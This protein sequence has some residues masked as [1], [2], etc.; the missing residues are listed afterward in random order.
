ML[1][2]LWAL[3]E[4]RGFN[5]DNMANYYLDCETQGLNPD[6]DEIVTIQYQK[7]DFNTGE[8]AGP[9]VILKAWESSEKDILEKF[10]EVFGKEEWGFIAHGYN[11]KFE[12]NFLFTRSA[13]NGFKEPINLMSRPIID[14]HPV[15]VLLNDGKFKGSGLHNI[16][17]KETNGS[18]CLEFYRNKEYK[19]MESYI[20]QETEAFLKLYVWLRKRMPKVLLEYKASLI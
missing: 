11:L 6:H 9:L 15:G 13:I 19:R 1:M 18:S 20:K 5:K 10:A 3:R 4:I 16:S 17:T 14:L 7:L 8:P 12:H 2:A